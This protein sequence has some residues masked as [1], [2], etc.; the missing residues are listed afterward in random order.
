MKL[1]LI[2]ILRLIELVVRIRKPPSSSACAAPLLLIRIVS[3][4]FMVPAVP[5]HRCKEQ[6]NLC[7]LSHFPTHDT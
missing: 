7:Q 4:L 1:L 5:L 3:L 6:M 2:L